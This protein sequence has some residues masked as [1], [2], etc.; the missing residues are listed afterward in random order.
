MSAPFSILDIG[1]RINSLSVAYCDLDE[2][3]DP[4]SRHL[5]DFGGATFG[6]A[7][8]VDIEFLH[9]INVTLSVSYLK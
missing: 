5:A 8:G 7:S 1:R 9:T 6:W 2:R 4:R 3:R